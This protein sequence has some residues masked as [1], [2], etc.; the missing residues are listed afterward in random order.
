MRVQVRI[1]VLVGGPGRQ[2]QGIHCVLGILIGY[3]L[4][5]FGLKTSDIKDSCGPG[6]GSYLAWLQ[7]QIMRLG[8]GN[9]QITH[10]GMVTDHLPG[11]EL[12]WV[13]GG[14]HSG[15][16]LPRVI[17]LGKR[18][19]RNGKQE[20]EEQG[21]DGSWHPPNLTLMRIVIKFGEVADMVIRCW[22]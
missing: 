16:S 14:N 9:R 22:L 19:T 12:K 5:Q 17:L 21:D 3:Y 8:T 2:V 10:L 13:Q 4:V 6:Q 11:D 7:G 15:L 1:R 18:A 20:T